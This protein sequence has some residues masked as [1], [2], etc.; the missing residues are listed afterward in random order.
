MEDT[1]VSNVVLYSC[2]IDSVNHGTS[3]YLTSKFF[4]VPWALSIRTS[5]EKPD[6]AQ[7][8]SSNH[9][10]AVSILCVLNRREGCS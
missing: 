3:R 4:T 7:E 8:V 1:K 10:S 6:V 9:G 2:K 5:L